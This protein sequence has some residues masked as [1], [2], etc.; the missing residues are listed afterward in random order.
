MEVQRVRKYSRSLIF[1][2]GFTILEML[3]YTAIVGMILTTTVYVT[4][5]IYNIRARVSS[6]SVVHESMVFAQ[7]RVLTTLHNATA[8]TF[9]LSGTSSTLSLTMPDAQRDPTVYWL[10][11][12]QI[13]VKEGSKAGLP[14]TSSEV[15]IS[16]LQFTRGANE[17][18]V[19]RVQI[20]G[21]RK[22]AK[23]AYSAPLTLTTSGVIRLEQ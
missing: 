3:I 1:R 23:A 13:W 9:P 20:S 14:L 8:V 12:G 22:N 17:P 5:T 2:S 18:P 7:K 11:G 15:T 16:S 19:I 4:S 10:Q 6:S 21:D